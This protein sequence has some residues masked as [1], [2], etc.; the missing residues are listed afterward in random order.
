MILSGHD[1]LDSTSIPQAA[2]DFTKALDGN[3]KGLKLGLPKEYMIGG[4]DPQVKAAVTAAV[5]NLQ[6]QGAEVVEIS[7]PHTDYAVAVYYIIA[8]A[9]A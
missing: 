4:L 8:T 6:K 9:E 7:L 2:P 5:E 1:S 3:I